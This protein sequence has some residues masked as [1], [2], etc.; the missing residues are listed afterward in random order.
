MGFFSDS[1]FFSVFLA[2]EQKGI[3]SQEGKRKNSEVEI[4]TTPSKTW[5]RRT[6]SL[7]WMSYHSFEKRT[8]AGCPVDLLEGRLSG[9]ARQRSTQTN[10]S[11]CSSECSQERRWGWRRSKKRDVCPWSWA[12]LPAPFTNGLWRTGLLISSQPTVSVSAQTQ[13]SELRTGFL[14]TTAVPSKDL[15]SLQEVPV[16]TRENA[17][18]FIN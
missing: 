17:A 1:S 18:K 6:S 11:L 12:V 16:A 8:E 10:P 14:N 3:S 5:L 2:N 9:E 7:S 15:K 13:N 4:T